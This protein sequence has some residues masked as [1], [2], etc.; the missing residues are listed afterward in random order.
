MLRK[1]RESQGTF[2]VLENL[3]YPD[4]IRE[5]LVFISICVFPTSDET[6]H[7]VGPKILKILKLCLHS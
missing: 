1:V 5:F 4:K 2:Y 3:Y 6:G 7:Q